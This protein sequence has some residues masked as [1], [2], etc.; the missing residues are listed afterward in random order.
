MSQQY[1]NPPIREAVCEFRYQEDGR[2]DSAAPGLIYSA[3]SNEFPRRLAGERSA[4]SP[5]PVA[6]S[7]NLSSPGLP[8]LE[9]R[10]V[11]QSPLRFWREGDELGY[12]AVSPYRLSVHHFRPYPSWECL[13]GIVAKGVQ[14]YQD[15]LNPKKVQRIGLRYIND[16]FFS[17]ATVELEEFF[18]FYPFVGQNIPQ[19]LTRFHCL[20][21]FDFEGA[22]DSLILQI[23]NGPNSESEN[24]QITLDLDYFLARP[25]A[26]ELTQSNEWLETAH[27]NLVSVFEGCLKDSTRKLFR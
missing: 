21:Q 4:V 19:D 22:R 9:M 11:H 7:P 24:A 1:L 14:A 10:I 27:A 8:Q 13:S 6:E 25:D 15:V 26:F 20:V 2:W 3:M 18:D 5:A 23:G 16:I 17:Q 12:I